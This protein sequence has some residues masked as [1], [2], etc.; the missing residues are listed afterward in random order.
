VLRGREA[1]ESIVVQNFNTFPLALDVTLHFEADFADMFEVRSIVSPQPHGRLLLP[2]YENGVLTFRYAG[3]DG[4]ARET[5]VRFDPPPARVERGSASYV[6]DLPAHGSERVALKVRIDESEGGRPRYQN[7]SG[8]AAAGAPRQLTAE[9]STIDTSNALLNALLLQ[10]QQDLMLLLSGDRENWFLAAGIPW[11]ATLFGRDALITALAEVWLSPSLAQ[12]T[13]RVLA[14]FQGTRDDPWRDEEP[15]KMPH[16]LRRGEIANLGLVPFTPYYGTVDATPL[17]VMLLGRY[18][19]TTGDLDLVRELLGPLEA[20]LVWINRFGDVDGDGFIE[21]RCRSSAGL[22]NQGWKDSSD[23]IVHADGSTPEPPIA[24]VEAQAYV[25][26]AKRAA[27]D[28]YRAL[29]ERARAE[30]LVDE[31]ARLR[32]AFNEAFWMPDEGFYCLALDGK[33]RQ[34]TSIAS[35]AGHALWC[36]IV[37]PDRGDAVARRLMAEDL[38]NGWGIRTLS[39]REVA[40]NPTGYHVGTVWPHDNAIIALALK[41]ANQEALALEL[42]AGMFDAAQHFPSFR[43]P[44]LFCGFARTAFGVPVRYPVACSPQAWAAAAWSAFLQAMLGIRPNAPA[45]ELVIGHPTLPPWLQ[46]VEIHHLTVGQATV[47]LRFERIGNH[48]AVDVAAMH[49]DVLVK[50]VAEWERGRAR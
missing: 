45:R 2:S 40:Y 21:Y 3:R 30:A 41:R 8:R 26:A 19:D 23:G 50:L 28:L 43:M 9:R 36:G 35:N 7:R 6:L 25:Y 16:E 29:G 18:H 44:E 34:V 49:G 24:L 12:Q 31:A 37:S 39:A 42:I 20:A 11:Y 10:S 27:A 14:H 32:D 1:S 17:W 48:T 33:K 38:F 22:V 46:W 15:G 5:T 13:L 4:I 47:D